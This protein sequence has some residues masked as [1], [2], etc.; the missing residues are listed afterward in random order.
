MLSLRYNQEKYCMNWYCGLCARIWRTRKF[1]FDIWNVGT[2]PM[3]NVGAYGVEIKDIFISCTTLNIETLETEQFSNAE[4]KFG[5]RKVFLKTKPK[6][7]MSSYQCVSGLQE[8]SHS[9]NRLW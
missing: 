7:N 5:Y 9:K 6:T 2:A 4:C 1:I 8:K 3:Q